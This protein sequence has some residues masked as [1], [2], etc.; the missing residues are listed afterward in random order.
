MK[1]DSVILGN[2]GKSQYACIN[3]LHGA[4]GVPCESASSMH[5]TDIHITR[6]VWC[7]ISECFV[8]ACNRYTLSQ[9]TC[10][11]SIYGDSRLPF[12]S[13]SSICVTDILHMF[14]RNTRNSQRDIY[15]ILT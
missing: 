10:N 9:Y 11:E 3:T 12:V 2:K 4:S 6:S 5:V 15:S 13:A 1:H 8:N 14:D 7:S